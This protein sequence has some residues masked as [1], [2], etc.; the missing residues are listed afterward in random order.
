MVLKN[1]LCDCQAMLKHGQRTGFF[2][3]KIQH[4]IDRWQNVWIRAWFVAKEWVESLDISSARCFST[5]MS[6]SWCFFIL[7]VNALFDEVRVPVTGGQRHECHHLRF[8][9]KDKL[10][11]SNASEF[12]FFKC[13][14]LT[15]A[16]YTNWSAGLNPFTS[17]SCLYS[18][19]LE[20]NSASAMPLHVYY[21]RNIDHPVCSVVRACEAFCMIFSPMDNAVRCCWYYTKIFNLE[22][23][24]S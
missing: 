5:W 21:R 8:L 24:A 1:W 18:S 23:T 15:H 17:S 14:L 13:L 12:N 20:R 3:K 11:P 16:V 7:L 19:M 2:N 4:C 10:I 6:Y 9:N 22:I